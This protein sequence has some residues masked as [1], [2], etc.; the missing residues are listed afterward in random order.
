MQSR[1]FQQY[2]YKEFFEMIF[3]LYCIMH[4]YLE[5]FVLKKLA[6]FA[7]HINKILYGRITTSTYLFISIFL[8]RM[9]IHMKHWCSIAKVICL[10]V[11]CYNIETCFSC[12]PIQSSGRN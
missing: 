7:L 6:R 8:I 5:I 12:Q 4:Y 11:Y 1:N 9:Q 2:F 10:E 3:M